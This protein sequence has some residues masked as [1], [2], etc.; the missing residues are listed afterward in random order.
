VVKK[1]TD[2]TC[3]ISVDK[4]KMKIAILNIIINALEALEPV[5]GGQLLIETQMENN[6]CRIYISDNGPGMDN[7]SVSKLFEPYFTTKPRGNGLGLTN[8][9]NIVLNHKGEIVVESE[10][11]KGTKFI[12][13]LD[14]T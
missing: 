10:P 3:K 2:K 11:D 4:E 5:E 14:I 8:T 1:L 6:K 7:E 12:I 13:I 9:Q